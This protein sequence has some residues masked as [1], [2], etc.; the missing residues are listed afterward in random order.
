MENNS[1]P[2]FH[3]W[4]KVVALR[5]HSES[6]FKKGDVLYKAVLVQQF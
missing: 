1:Q 2:P 6:L 3:L 5:D 4:Q